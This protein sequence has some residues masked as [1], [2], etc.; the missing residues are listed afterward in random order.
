MFRDILNFDS[1]VDEALSR[2]ASSPRTCSLHLGVGA[3]R[4]KDPF[5]LVDYSVNDVHIYNDVNF[6][7]YG[8]HTNKGGVLYYD[9]HWQP[10]DDPCLPALVNE[11]HGQ[12]TPEVVL[13]NVTALHQTGDMH[14]A[15][16]DFA[17]RNL[18]VSNAAVYDAAVG[19]TPQP[20][21][22]RSFVQ[23]SMDALW[24]EPKPAAFEI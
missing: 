5:R 21:Y 2:I 13:R 22:D 6:P 1:S 18:Y 19:S 3:A 23:L 4:D 8:T 14:I 15:V 7:E 11:F 16:M 9:Q 17:G 24:N 20:A 12:L 10:S